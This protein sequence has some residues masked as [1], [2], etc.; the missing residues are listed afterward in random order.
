MKQLGIE[1]IFD[2]Q[3]A[4]FER[5][6]LEKP[7]YLSNIM[8]ETHIGIDEQGVEGAAYTMIAAAGATAM[9]TDETYAEMILDRPFLYGILDRESGAWLFL[10]VC[11]NPANQM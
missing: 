10:G 7:L 9:L 8:Q 6:S 5:I 1:H 4:D 3:T 2:E 11:S